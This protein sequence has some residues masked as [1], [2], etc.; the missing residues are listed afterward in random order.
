M[1]LWKRTPLA[2]GMLS[3]LAGFAASEEPA[4]NRSLYVP[5]RFAPCEHLEHA[6]LYRGDDPIRE[7]PGTHVFQ[8]TYYPNLS[9]LEPQFERVRIEGEHEGTDFRSEIVVTPASVY[10][11]KKKI[12]LDLDGQIERLKHSIDARHETVELSL[13]CGTHCRRS[14]RLTSAETS[15]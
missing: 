6:V 10:I 9:R 12:D 13:K 1:S 11:G 15:P 14:A 2:L 8:F 4:L 5:V 7:L 3:I